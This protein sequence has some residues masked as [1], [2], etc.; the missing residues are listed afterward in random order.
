MGPA[1]DHRE[2]LFE[3]QRKRLT[4]LAYRILG[5]RADAEDIVQ[6]CYLRWECC[7]EPV[8]SAEAWLTTVVTRLAV[9]RLRSVRGQR[10]VYPGT[11]LPE[12]IVERRAWSPLERLEAE[13]DLSIAFL[14]LMERLTP[15]ERAAFVLRE[16]FDYP[17]GEVAGLL[18]R[19]EAACR[20]LVHRAKE[21]LRQDRPQP[22]DRRAQAGL[23]RRY[24][25]AVMTQNEGALLELLSA[26]A[27]EYS[28]GGGK[29]R[30]ALHPIE[31]ADRVARFLFGLARKY[32]RRF[33][34]EPAL[35]NSEPGAIV[36]VDGAPVVAAFQFDGER[37][38]RIFHILNPDKLPGIQTET[39]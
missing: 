29:V 18:D 14:F 34:I 32:E 22:S 31:G 1:G 23:V 28:D 15:E 10:E 13:A 38:T 26:D 7:G 27:R 35:V 39:G 6:E 37:I 11:W 20:Q 19:S 3:A 2:T 4:G 17:Y 25:D 33:S 16:G 21:R 8:R 9:D 12:P 36:W 5:S 24:V 30:A